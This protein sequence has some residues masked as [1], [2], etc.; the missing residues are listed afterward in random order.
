[1]AGLPLTGLEVSLGAGEYT[2]DLSGEW[3]RD[4]DVS[5]DAGAADLNVR[6]PKDVGARVEV[7][8]GPHTIDASDLAQDENVYTNAAYGES[9]V[10]MNVD[11]QAGIGSIDLEVE[12]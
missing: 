9:E 3:A 11:V 5:I 1:L 8:T 7:E 2:I 6:L 4:L 12:E 10:T